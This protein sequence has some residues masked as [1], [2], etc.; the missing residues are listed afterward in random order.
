M[1]KCKKR[2]LSIH[3]VLFLLMLVLLNRALA[4]GD[5]SSK[6]NIIFHDNFTDGVYVNV[7]NLDNF[8]LE[9]PPDSDLN[10]SNVLLNDTTADNTF[11]SSDTKSLYELGNLTYLVS[12]YPSTVQGFDQPFLLY[13]DISVVNENDIEV[14]ETIDIKEM[15][16]KI[17]PMLRQDI[18]NYSFNPGNEDAFLVNHTLTVGL[19]PEENAN[20]TLV[21]MLNPFAGNLNCKKVELG[22][23]IPDVVFVDSEIPLNTTVKEEC[24]FD[25]RIDYLKFAPFVKVNISSLSNNAINSLLS[26][27]EYVASFDDGIITFALQ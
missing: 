18:L 2:F 23:L 3:G 16:N 20:F 24:V 27:N 14:N 13:T 6:Q 17:F 26:L 22:D 9:I 5:E 19:N 12:I 21:L 7:D 4:F 25:I 10:K 15:L 1:R 11:Q 8:S